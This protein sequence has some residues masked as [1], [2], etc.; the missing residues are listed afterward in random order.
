MVTSFAQKLLN[1]VY[2]IW[3]SK[4]EKNRKT[5]KMFL[6]S[7]IEEIFLQIKFLASKALL[8]YVGCQL[9]KVVIVNL[10]N[11]NVILW[12]EWALM[13]HVWRN[14]NE[15]K[16]NKKYVLL[17]ENTHEKWIS[18]QQQQMIINGRFQNP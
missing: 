8:N 2:L 17:S 18:R 7:L 14:E 16:I 5:S 6:S 10:K 4:E 15:F 3:R 12:G 1:T 11:I 9:A 13:W